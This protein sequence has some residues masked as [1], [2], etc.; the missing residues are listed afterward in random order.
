[1]LGLHDLLVHESTV[2]VGLGIGRGPDRRRQ[3]CQQSQA[4]HDAQA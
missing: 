4:F 2:I 3:D 1:M